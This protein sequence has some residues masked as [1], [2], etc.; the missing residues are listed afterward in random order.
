MPA[1]QTRNADAQLLGGVDHLFAADRNF[2]FEAYDN[3]S[4]AFTAEQVLG[5]DV[6]RI[7][8]AP[9][10]FSLAANILTVAIAGVFLFNIRSTFA[11]SGGGAGQVAFY[12]QEDPD[13][14][15]FVTIPSALSY[16]YI[17]AALNATAQIVVPVLVNFD[18]RY[19]IAAIRTSGAGTVS[20]VNQTT[21]LSAVLLYNNT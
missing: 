3:L 5:L 17:P 9:E 7:N 20:T 13:T 15:T 2:I 1:I 8:H 16:V 12:L 10:F 11:M 6:E 19:R 21:T 4:D 14:G 18:Y